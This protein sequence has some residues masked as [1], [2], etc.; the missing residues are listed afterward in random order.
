MSGPLGI[1][2]GGGSLPRQ[3][4][5]L[6]RSS[7]RGAFVVAIE[8]HTDPATVAGTDHLWVRMGQ[9]EKAVRA[10]KDAGVEDLVMVGAV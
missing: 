9:S 10:L 4:V 6:C 3:L 8:G 1:V 5:D 7:G 2:A